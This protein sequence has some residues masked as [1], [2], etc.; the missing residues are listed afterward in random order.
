MLRV[1]TVFGATGFIGRH[2]IQRLAKTGAQV[3]VVTR[4]TEAAK[5]LK[6]MGNVGQIVPVPCNLG[7]ATAESLAPLVDGADAVVNLVGLLAEGGHQTF[8]ALQAEG[9]GKIAA[10]AAKAGVAK[11]VQVSAIGAD[12]GSDAKYAATK[13]Q[14]EAAVREAFP[15][16]VILRPSIVFGPEDKFFNRFASMA[17]TFPVVPVVGPK[18]RFQPVYVGDVADAIMACLRRADVAGRTFELGGPRSY[19]FAELLDIIFGA[20]AVKKPVIALPFGIAALV[21][22][23]IGLL[24]GK[25]LTS[26]QVKLLKQDNVVSPGAS[27]LGDLGIEPESVEAIVPSYLTRFRPGGRFA[28]LRP[29]V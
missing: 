23:I 7:A 2:L 12:A 28:G 4:D 15:A 26:D 8:S 13:A 25:L 6:P 5:F 11:F 9:P 14:G 29:G 21:A 17:R 22:P 10:A 19:S 3:R 16:A 24:P 1:V 18:T 20:I 27:T